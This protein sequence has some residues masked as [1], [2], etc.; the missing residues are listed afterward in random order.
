VGRQVL[1]ALPELNRQLGLVAAE[2]AAVL[3][4]LAQAAQVA[5]EVTVAAV[6]AV[7]EHS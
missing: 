5:V 6:V 3:T 1:L 2:V 4:P 7:V